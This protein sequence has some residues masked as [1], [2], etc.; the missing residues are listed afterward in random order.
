MKIYQIEKS[1]FLQFNFL[2]SDSQQLLSNSTKNVLHFSLSTLTASINNRED[3]NVP[4]DSTVT[5]NN[6]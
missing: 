5:A 2:T 6:C 4:T 1:N 3:G